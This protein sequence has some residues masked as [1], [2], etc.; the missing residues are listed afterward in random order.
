MAGLTCSAQVT[1][2]ARLTKSSLVAVCARLKVQVHRLTEIGELQG[3]PTLGNAHPA[4]ANVSVQLAADVHHTLT[5][6]G[7]QAVHYAGGLRERG[8]RI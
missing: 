1:R 5:V 8:S 4:K 6:V 7:G 2:L 3:L